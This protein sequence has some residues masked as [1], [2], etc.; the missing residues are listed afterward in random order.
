MLLK[1]AKSGVVP[2][3]TSLSWGGQEGEKGG[4]RM[5]L[6]GWF[7]R[8]L[9]IASFVLA[10]VVLNLAAV[11]LTAGVAYSQTVD[12]IIVEGNRRVEA[13]TIRSYFKAGPGGHLNAQILDDG[14]KALYA[15]G[16]FQDVRISQSGGRIVVSVLEN[17][18]INRIAFEGNRKVRD[19][20]LKGEIQSKERGTLS[21]PLVQSDVQRLVEVYRRGGASEQPRRPGIRN[22]RR[23]EDRHQNHPF[24]RQS[25]L[26]LVPPEGRDQDCANRLLCLPADHEYL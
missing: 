6:C 20:Q 16:L 13:A 9:G 19:E 14:Y 15:T 23:P 2:V 25:R 5:N 21:R 1:P 17:P 12:S 18:V 8:G 10:G 24:R 26:Q 7:V 11:S 3:Q 22:Q 4:L